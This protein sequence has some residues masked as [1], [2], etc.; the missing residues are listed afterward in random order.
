[1]ALDNAGLFSEVESL[2][3]QQTAALG[4]LAEAVTIQDRGGRLVYANEAAARSLGFAS[5][6]EL[7]ATPP[8]QVV[9][10]FES[11]HEDGR[12]LRVADLPGRRV[13]A[14]EHP[15]PLLVRARNRETGEERWRTVKATAVP[16]ADGR[17][18]LAVNVIDDVTEVK[19]A[20]LRQRFLARAGEVLASSMEHG[21]TLQQVADLAVP[22]LA[23]WC[24]VTI[25]DEQG[26]LRPVAVAH[27]DPEMVRWAREYARHHAEHVTGDSGG[28]EVVRDGRT[29]LVQDITDDQLVAAAD[30]PEQLAAL[31][32]LGMRSVVIVPMA[33]SGGVI[34]TIS[35]VSAE[36]RRTFAPEDVELA[37]ELARRAGTAIENARLY[38]ERSEIARVLQVGLLPR[39]LPEVPGFR[40]AA[41]YRPAGDQN[42]VGGDFYEAFATPAGWMVSVG[43]VT[44]R[45]AEAAALT[46]EARHVLRT[47]AQLTGDPVAAVAHLNAE[48]VRKPRTSIVTVALALL[49]GDAVH[50]VCAGHP[51]PLLV[52]GG[53]VLTAGACG[54]LVGA[55]PDSR[56][57]VQRTDLRP[58]DLVVL[59]TDGI[60]DTRG[61]HERFGEE[62]L[63]EALR[64]TREAED[65]LDRVLRAVEGFEHGPQADDTA[66]VVLECVP[67]AVRAGEGRP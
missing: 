39:A 67:A 62:R 60:T 46:A 55:W 31:R 64:G 35:F 44:G 24:V 53:E 15:E 36:S 28:A 40:V 18:R 2:E 7:L 47:V 50:V 45:G 5:A 3:A 13:L 26:Y 48:L 66:V 11:F 33:A 52:R 19:R 57:S 61:V 49:E 4:S 59:Y 56:W 32:R 34:G 9:D 21:E 38:T 43:D 27:G 30:S 54:P 14:G 37:E 22:E 25:P 6:A 12:P 8:A 20:E 10:A 63:V 65:A 23:D 42:V 51:L 29:L 17:P 16:G 1:L 58:G 41:L